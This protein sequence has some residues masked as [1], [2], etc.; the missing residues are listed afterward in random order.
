MGPIEL[1]SG[2]A[3]QTPPLWRTNASEAEM[4]SQIDFPHA[5][6][7][8]DFVGFAAGEHAAVID[9]VGA[10]ADAQSLAHVVVSDEHTDLALFQ[11]ADDF[12]DVEHGYGVDAGE[13]FIEQN[14]AWLRGESPRDFH[15]TALAATRLP[16]S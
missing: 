6:I 11:E 7:I 9:D 1:S 13:W 3:W 4:L 16:E 12:L 14:E 5:L 2:S 15:A 10:V 8:N